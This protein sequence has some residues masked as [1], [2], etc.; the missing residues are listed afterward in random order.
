TALVYPF[1]AAQLAGLLV[2]GGFINAA[3]AMLSATVAGIAALIMISRLLKIEE[4][5]RAIEMLTRRLK[6]GKKAAGL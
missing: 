1:A 4:A 6:P 2:A 3:A 5:D